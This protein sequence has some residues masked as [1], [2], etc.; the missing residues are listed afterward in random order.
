MC[1]RVRFEVLRIYLARSWRRRR[2]DIS[3][4]GGL[5][6]SIV[7]TWTP[8]GGERARALHSILY[9][10]MSQNKMQSSVTRSE[11]LGHLLSA[12]TAGNCHNYPHVAICSMVLLRILSIVTLLRW[13]CSV[14][15]V[16]QDGQPPAKASARTPLKTNCSSKIPY[17]Y[18]RTWNHWNVEENEKN[19]CLRL[20]SLWDPHGNRVSSRWVGWMPCS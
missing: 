2:S 8:F 3:G 11:V 10:V 1:C 14:L 17:L 13:C 19:V 18:S 12:S 16:E 20:K 15:S 4:D 6:A 9:Q 7:T 5:R